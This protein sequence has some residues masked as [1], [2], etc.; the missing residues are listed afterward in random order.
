MIPDAASIATA[1]L[2]SYVPMM[3]INSPTNPHVIGTAIDPA[4]MIKNKT[5]NES[6]L[7]LFP[8]ALILGL[9]L[10]VI[11]APTLLTLFTPLGS[12]FRL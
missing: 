3:I 9:P 4:V 6:T 7:P 5:A 1:L 11:T 8:L 12:G 2:T 10:G